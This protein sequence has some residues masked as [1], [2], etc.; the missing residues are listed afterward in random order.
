MFYILYYI[1]FLVAIAGN[2]IPAIATT[3]AM[4]AGLVVLYA[5]RV[6]AEQYDKCVS[7]NLRQKSV[8]TKTVVS[9]ETTIMPPFPNC[10]VCSEKPFVNIFVNVNKM[11]IK[12]LESEILK[13]N[14]NMIAPD[15]IIDGKGVIII[16]SEEGETEVSLKNS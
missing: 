3:N 7:V 1:S 6:L 5:F 16:S 12:E 8:H 11:T 13:K 2:I 4:I 9:A 10:Y 15:A 14:L